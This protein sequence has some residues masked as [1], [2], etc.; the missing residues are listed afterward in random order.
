MKDEDLERLMKIGIPMAALCTVWGLV[1]F[2]WVYKG[3]WKA[4]GNSSP[5][6]LVL[7]ELFLV[8]LLIFFTYYMRSKWG[9]FRKK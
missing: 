2:F 6:G 8:G 4:G 3:D 9:W 5:I 7:M 1:L